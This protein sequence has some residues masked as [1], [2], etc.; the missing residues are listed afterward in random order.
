[1][2]S[3]NWLR[4]SR[5]LKQKLTDGWQKVIRI[6]HLVSLRLSGEL[7]NYT[8]IMLS[9]WFTQVSIMNTKLIKCKHL[10]AALNMLPALVGLNQAIS[11]LRLSFWRHC[12]WFSTI[13]DYILNKFPQTK[14]NIYNYFLRNLHT[15]YLN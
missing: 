5:L 10:N 3:G 7:K 13:T 12:K 6:A 4:W 8:V 1:M 15:F 9:H 11:F 2:E 14:I